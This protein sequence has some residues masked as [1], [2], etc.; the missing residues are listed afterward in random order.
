MSKQ[1]HYISGAE[2]NLRRQWERLKV[3][4]VVMLV[5]LLLSQFSN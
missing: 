3:I 2:I 5:L 1:Q 4:A